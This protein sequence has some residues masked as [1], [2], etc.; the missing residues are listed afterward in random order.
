M[1]R[2]DSRRPLLPSLLDRLIDDAPED[3][4]ERVSEG[5]HSLAELR[6]AIRRD[7]ENLLNTRTRRLEWPADAPLVERSVAAYGIP[8][9]SGRSLGSATQRQAFLRSVE[10]L[11]RRFEPRFK[12]VK[13][14]PQS[15]RNPY[16]RALHFSIQAEVYA[17][18]A[19]EPVSF[20]TT[21][22]PATRTLVVALSDA[23]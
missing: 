22:E 8:D 4:S 14:Q 17:E 3:R 5:Y 23:R 21:V 1:A 6:V 15:A 2:S 20:D 18:P 7:L 10:E 11:I 16:D 12:S 13:V 9:I 19:P